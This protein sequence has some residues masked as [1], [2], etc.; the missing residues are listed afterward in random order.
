[1][2]AF[3]FFFFE[4]LFFVFLP[5]P[6][7]TGLAVYFPLYFSFFLQDIIDKKRFDFNDYFLQ[8]HKTVCKSCCT[9]MVMMVALFSINS[10][11]QKHSAG[12]RFRTSSLQN[13]Q[14]GGFTFNNNI[15]FY[16]FQK[17]W[18]LEFGGI[19][20]LNLA[21]LGYKLISFLALEKGWSSVS[22][23]GHP[24]GIVFRMTGFFLYILKIFTSNHFSLSEW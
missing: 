13:V 1:M 23:F 16:Q 11:K 18:C 2:N 9:E 12:F 3:L 4:S 24:A 8:Q 22:E 19:F 7:K 21:C 15:I 10:L 20:R 5:A 14:Y 6:R 17:V